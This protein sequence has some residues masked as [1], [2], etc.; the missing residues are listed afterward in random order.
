MKHIHVPMF[1][2]PLFSVTKE[3]FD[4]QTKRG[5]GNGGQNRNKRDTAVR[6]V[7]KASG[8]VGE[9]Q[10]EREQG[11]NKRLAFKR[12]TESIVFKM[13]LNKKIHEMTSGETI[14]QKVEKAMSSSN[15]KIETKNEEGKWT[16]TKELKDDEN[17]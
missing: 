5:S 8:A 12:L 6:I 4:I 15:I 16:E 7:H 11:Q 9:A 2:K 14:E 3:D 13:W 17:I 10:D 1:D